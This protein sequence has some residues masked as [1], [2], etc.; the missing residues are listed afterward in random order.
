LP[1]QEE[2][3]AKTAFSGVNFHGKDYLYQ[4]KFL[5]FGL[6]NVPSKFQHVMDIILARLDFV[7]CYIDDIV[8]YNDT[9][10]EH[11]SHL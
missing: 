8:V 1:I 6:K 2:D 10:E 7:R 3:K 11:Q 5:I 9:V 4:W